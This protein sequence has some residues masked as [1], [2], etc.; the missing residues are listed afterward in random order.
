MRK[1][2]E[3]CQRIRML[4]ALVLVAVFAALLYVNY[5]NG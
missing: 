3:T 4:S 1:G 2:C 5:L